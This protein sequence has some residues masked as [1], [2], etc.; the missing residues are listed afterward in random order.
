M[1]NKLNYVSQNKGSGGGWHRDSIVP[2]IKS[3][4]YLV[5][6]DTDIGPIEIV[7]DSNKFQNILL[8]NK[9]M[10]N[11]LLLNTRFTE[12]QVKKIDNFDE[13]LVSIKAK[14]G[15]MI[16]FDGSNIHRGRPIKK[17]VR[18]AI[19]NYY[20]PIGKM[21]QKKYPLRPQIFN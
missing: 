19:T 3:L 16:I 5:D 11:K 1:A 7:K 9:K 17:N 18:Y 14:K 15:T 21:T 8:D 20:F 12:D 13:R 10:N 6:V 2:N 4:V